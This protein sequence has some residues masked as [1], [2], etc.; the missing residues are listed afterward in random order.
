MTMIS[1]HLAMTLADYEKRDSTGKQQESAIQQER[2]FPEIIAET[3]IIKGNAERTPNRRCG[4]SLN[5]GV[6]HAECH[7][8]SRDEE[9][10]QSTLFPIHFAFLCWT[11][12][13]N[14]SQL[15]TVL[16]QMPRLRELSDHF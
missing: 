4:I 11:R 2:E 1:D 7:E 13:Q 8:R 5:C 9:N 16:L 3:E 6:R 14:Q 15:P 10:S 12:D